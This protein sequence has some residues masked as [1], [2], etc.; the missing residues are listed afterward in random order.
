MYTDSND[1]NMKLKKDIRNGQIL[2]RKGEL[3]TCIKE[4]FIFSI[5]SL[6]HMI[7]DTCDRVNN[8]Y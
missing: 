6:F 5:F 3:V 4:D 7:N 1:M 8:N 2:N